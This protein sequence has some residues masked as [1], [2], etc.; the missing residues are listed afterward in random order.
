MRH[1]GAVER[2]W[3]AAVIAILLLC[4]AAAAKPA[5]KV[6]SKEYDAGTIIEGSREYV[7][8]AFRL[9][10]TGDEPLKIIKVRP[11]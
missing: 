7:T 11:G 9:K 10:N 2:N 5:V 1:L 6:D 8:H 4:T 3:I